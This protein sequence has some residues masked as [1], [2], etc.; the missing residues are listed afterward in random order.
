ML[1]R[2]LAVLPQDFG[3]TIHP[4][5]SVFI[6]TRVLTV[7]GFI[8]YSLFFI[9]RIARVTAE[10][11]I[12]YRRCAYKCFVYSVQQLGMLP[13][14]WPFYKQRP[15]SKIKY[16]FLWKYWEWKRWCFEKNSANLDAPMG[17]KAW[18][19]LDL[20]WWINNILQSGIQKS[21]YYRCVKK[22]LHHRLPLVPYGRWIAYK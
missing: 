12:A 21:I 16:V 9:Q 22:R 11:A 15:C 7:W 19:K 3:L 1:K 10:K 6:P 8:I 20:Q 18:T 4:D 2:Q 14:F 17:L 13:F 5:K